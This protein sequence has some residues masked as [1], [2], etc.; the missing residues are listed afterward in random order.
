[1]LFGVCCFCLPFVDCC[2]LRVV[3]LLYVSWCS[4][5]VICVFDVG[6]CVVLC[7]FV[8]LLVVCCCCLALLFDA[9]IV[10]CCCLI[11]YVVVCC[12]LFVFRC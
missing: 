2:V 10:V 4:M 3:F 6:D 8:S 11:A 9:G 12:V 1:M 7:C 5:F